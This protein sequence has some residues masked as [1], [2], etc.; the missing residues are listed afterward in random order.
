MI[1]VLLFIAFYLLSGIGTY[2]YAVIKT[3]EFINVWNWKI[4]KDYVGICKYP[5]WLMGWMYWIARLFQ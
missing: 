4:D 2:I 3:Y 5:K 1:E